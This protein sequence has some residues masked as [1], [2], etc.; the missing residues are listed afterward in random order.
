MCTIS[1]RG[2][3]THN[4]IRIQIV[5][6]SAPSTC[7][8]LAPHRMNARMWYGSTQEVKDEP[9]GNTHR[10]VFEIFYFFAI[11]RNHFWT[12]PIIFNLL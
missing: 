9:L 5:H 7:V 12:A 2:N 10:G 1:A 11:H 8:R 4:S 3:S 6:L